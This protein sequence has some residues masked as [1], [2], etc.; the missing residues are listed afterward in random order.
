MKFRI[1]EVK[2]NRNPKDKYAIYYLDELDNRG[3]KWN[4]VIWD[5]ESYRHFQDTNFVPDIDTAMFRAAEFK[6]KYCA[7][8]GYVV[9]EFEL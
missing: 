3:I 5:E 7:E 6:D 8:H 1:V 2:N 9:D 4:R